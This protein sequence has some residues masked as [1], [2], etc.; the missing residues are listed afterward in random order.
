MWFILIGGVVISI[1]LCFF[2]NS[3]EAYGRLR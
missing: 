1:F 2:F 3:V